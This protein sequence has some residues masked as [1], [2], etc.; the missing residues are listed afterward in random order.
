M[1]LVLS[2]AFSP[3]GKRILTASQDK[4]ARLWDP[5]TGKPIGAPLTG[6]AGGVLSATFSPDGRRIVTASEDATVR[7]W[8]AETHKPIGELR[9]HSNRVNSAA[10]SPDGKVIVTAS[11]DRT[12]R[13]WKIFTSAQELVSRA[14]ATIPR[15]L[16]L[17][18]RDSFFLPF[19][20]PPWCI[21]LEKWP[22]HADEWKQWLRDTRAGKSPS[23]PARE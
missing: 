19:E 16:T 12:A 21:D 13:V 22:Y 18:Q 17:A 10:F 11:E 7:L 6:H 4:T 15:C 3:D 14:K 20:P 9:G 2:A 1:D 8:D 23:P 5:E